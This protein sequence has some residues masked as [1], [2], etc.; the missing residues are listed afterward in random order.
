MPRFWIDRSCLREGRFLIKGPLYHHICRVCRIKKGAPFELYCE[1]LQKYR[2][3]L[4]FI[5]RS[6][7][8]ASILKAYPVPPLKNPRLRLAL[9]LPRPAK[10]DSLIEKAV[11]M[12]VKEIC[13]FVSA[14]SFLKKPRQI[15]P[16]RESR[17]KKIARQSLAQSGRAE[18]LI[19]KPCRFLQDIK[20]PKE[21][22][23]FM[24]YEGENRRRPLP[25]LLKKYPQPA[26]VWLFIGSE[27]GFSAEE[28]REFC[29]RENS[30]AFSFGD[31]ILKVE[32]ACLF[33]LSLLKC[34]Y[35]L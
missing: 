9:S 4:S 2:V 22:P 14:F 21:E 7:A 33:G 20:I 16:A 6:E 35:R 29:Q 31:Q 32:T 11:E 24:A 34:H 23:A 19:L 1:G 27:G 3:A 30:F 5:S 13:P 12:G 25:A 10:M 18:P 17:W 15:S 8:R 26:S 28:A